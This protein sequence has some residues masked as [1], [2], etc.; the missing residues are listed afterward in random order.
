LTSYQI[1]ISLILGCRRDPVP[2]G[3]EGA[4]PDLVQDETLRQKD[5]SLVKSWKVPGPS[6]FVQGRTPKGIN[7]KQSGIISQV[8]RQ[9]EGN[10]NSIDLPLFFGEN[11]F[12]T[13]GNFLKKCF[14]L[15]LKRLEQVEI[16]TSSHRKKEELYEFIGQKS[17]LIGHGKCF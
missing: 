11:E 3:A 17:E 2:R 13:S 15:I 5:C 16:T 1:H 4:N 9:E 7:P 8:K 14:L 10:W 12:K 6:I